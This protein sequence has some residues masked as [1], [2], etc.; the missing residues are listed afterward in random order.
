MSHV[1]SV[2][3]GWRAGRPEDVKR[4][5]TFLRVAAGLEEPGAAD[6]VR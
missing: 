5:T 4:Y 1:A 3:S 6:A 2:L